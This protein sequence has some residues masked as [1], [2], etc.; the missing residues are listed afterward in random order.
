M[1]FMLKN[2]KKK[3]GKMEKI[4]KRMKMILVGRKGT[5]QRGLK[6]KKV[7]HIFM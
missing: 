1:N 5:G 7:Y 4:Y 6:W 2:K 3:E